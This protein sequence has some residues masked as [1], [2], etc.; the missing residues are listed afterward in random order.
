MYGTIV[1][2]ISLSLCGLWHAKYFKIYS[3]R[4]K[5]KNQNQGINVIK[6]EKQLFCRPLIFSQKNFRLNKKLLIQNNVEFNKMDIDQTYH[7]SWSQKED[8]C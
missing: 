5:S 3:F 8:D 1:M 4:N 7:R 2:F 6:M